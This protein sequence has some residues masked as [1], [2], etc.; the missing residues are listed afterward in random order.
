MAKDT[1]GSGVGLQGV[2]K[3][4][5]ITQ[6]RFLGFRLRFGCSTRFPA[7]LAG[8]LVNNAH[9]PAHI[10][11]DTKA[12]A[13]AFFR[14]NEWLVSGMGCEVNLEATGAIEPLIT[15]AALM[16]CGRRGGAWRIERVGG[17]GVVVGCG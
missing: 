13:T 15:V 12:A 9:M 2:G 17:R 16:T 5:K 3:G 8:K 1:Y 6:G 4:Y 14:T 11:S 7:P 10:A